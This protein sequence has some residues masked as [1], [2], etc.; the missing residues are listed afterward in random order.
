MGWTPTLALLALSI[1]LV[2]LARFMSARP[3]R[4]GRARLVPWTAILVA[5]GALAV[6]MG[7]HA[8]SLLGWSP[9]PRF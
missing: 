6:I 1:G 9:P 7:V 8:L 2:V 3:V 4:L 5:A